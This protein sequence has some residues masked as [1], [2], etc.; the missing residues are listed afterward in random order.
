MS[1]PCTIDS[2]LAKIK[3]LQPDAENREFEGTDE[4]YA[5]PTHTFSES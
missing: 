4:L 2:D 1:S 5:L 3:V